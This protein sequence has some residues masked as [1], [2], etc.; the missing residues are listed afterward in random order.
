MQSG[1]V[2]SMLLFAGGFFLF[3]GVM[4]W[5]IVGVA[6]VI[7]R[8]VRREVDNSWVL[9]IVGAAFIS[10]SLS[11][12]ILAI[13]LETQ[14]IKEVEHEKEK[15]RLLAVEAENERRAEELE[16]ARQLQT[17]ML[18]KK[19]PNLPNLEIAAYMKPATEVGGDY[20]D[21]HLSK[22]GILTVAVGDAT[23]HGL[24]AGSVITVT[25]SLFNA[26]A[27]QTDIPQIL[28][29]TSGA[30]KKMNLRGLFMATTLMKLKDNTLNIRAAGMPST[31]VYR[32]DTQA[33]EELSTRAVPLG[34][35]TNFN[36]RGQEISL[37]PGDC[38][39]VMSDGFPE[40][41]NPA[42]EMH[43]FGKAAEVLPEFVS[44]SAA[45]IVENFV[46]I[47]EDWAGDHLRTM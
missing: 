38:V 21:F 44:K 46:R 22:D 3:L 33:V 13:D 5:N 19:L 8:A 30:L 14:L 16:E 10:D 42:G 43:G 23:G 11:S 2:V 41:F 34:S 26:F 12:T 32:A 36:Y 6:F 39:L 4:L 47:G 28:R 20:Y 17:S 37:R 31:L 35:M 40:M 29:Q 25:K 9:G 24:K 18:P 45:E 7:I 27:E 1:L 15:A